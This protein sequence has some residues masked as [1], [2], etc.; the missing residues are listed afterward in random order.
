MNAEIIAVGS[1]MLTPDRVDTNSLF[2]TDQ[3]NTMGVEV[4]RKSVVGDD[5][6]L[7]ANEIRAAFSQAEI[8]ILSGG[9]G[10]TEDDVTRESVADALSRKLVF[11]QELLEALTARF[12]R[13]NRTMAENNK[14]QTFLVEGA[15]GLP[16][17]RGTAA[18]QWIEHNGRVIMML[19]GPPH[20]LKTMFTEQ[21]LPRLTKM[22]PPQV[23]RTR[24]LRVAGMGESDLDQLIS[25]VYKTYTNPVTTILAG[26]GDIQIHM[27]AR[28]ATEDE[29]EALLNEVCPRCEQLLGNRVYSKDGSSIEAVIGQMLRARGATLS[30][31]ESC[32]GG[33]LGERITSVAG[34]SDYF[35]GGFLVYNDREKV[36]LLG[37]EASVLAMHTSVSE[38][39]AKA[40]AH[41]A[42]IRTGSTYAISVTGEA[43]PESSTGAPVGTVIIGL[44]GPEGDPM[45]ERYL[46]FGERNGI[47]ARA[48]Q[49][50]L[51]Y[52]RRHM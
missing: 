15:D 50:A 7:L 23:I 12:A 47:R 21:C 39:A 29:A 46:L 19:P 26:P 24:F 27:R 30:V 31:A 14:R 32:T 38:E 22:L 42:R 49:W 18:G 37:V 28:G 3:L 25:P 20:E 36:N 2:I 33:L 51:D 40:M 10:P 45:A 35:V 34:S 1:E 5:R 52:F 41:G 11:S 9:L 44:A 4:I 16:N 48:A 6:Q 17:P 43:G 8:V 13:L